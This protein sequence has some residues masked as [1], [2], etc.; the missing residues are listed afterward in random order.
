MIAGNLVL[1]V[2]PDSTFRRSLEF[3]LET[4]GFDVLSHTTVRHAF[5]SGTA[6]EAA[7]A[8]I[9]DAAIQDW[10]VAATQFGDF[11]RPVVLLV[12]PFRAVPAMQGV[13]I[14]P[15]PF[16]GAPL[17]DAVRLAADGRA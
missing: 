4:E 3:A 5:S 8:V 10:N 6:R 14:V 15:K 1:V 16:L 11:A 7:C 2:V 9:D 13:S 17:V 12:G